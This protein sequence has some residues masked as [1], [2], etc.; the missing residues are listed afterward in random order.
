MTKNNK[1][2]SISFHNNSIQVPNKP[3]I[4]FIEGDGIGPD[5]WKASVRVI[6]AAVKKA[7]DGQREIQWME[8]YAGEKAFRKYGKWLPQETI[9]AFKK[10]IVGIKGPLTTPVGEGIRSLNVHIRKSLDL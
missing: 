1:Y 6:D 3:T 4:P 2:Q 9:D 10:F 5:I 7:Y 8:V